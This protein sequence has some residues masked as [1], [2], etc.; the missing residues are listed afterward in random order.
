[1]DTPPVRGFYLVSTPDGLTLKHADAPSGDSGLRLDLSDDDAVRRA[2]GGKQSA[3]AKAFGLHRRA[4]SRVLDTTAGLGRDAC[5]LATLGC[6]VQSLERQP[7]LHALL[8]DARERAALVAPDWLA[9]WPTPIL[10]DAQRWIETQLPGGPSFDAI[11]IDPMF[12]S[13]RRK[14]KPQKALAWLAELAGTDDDAPALL[15][16]ARRH[17]RKRVVVKQH[18]RS[19]PLA[20]PDNQVVGKAVR[21]DIYLTPPVLE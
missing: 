1:V 7:A 16:V 21:F 19:A 4:P 12:A 13:S 20:P 18:G 15:A 8:C 11:Y 10:T 17:A 5:M 9:R 6:E 2:A 14:A 3:L